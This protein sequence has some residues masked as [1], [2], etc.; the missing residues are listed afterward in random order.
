M[1]LGIPPC[2][3]CSSPSGGLYG[4]LVRWIPGGCLLGPAAA[5]FGFVAA[6]LWRVEGPQQGAAESMAQL[7][8][9]LMGRGRVG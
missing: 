7:V 8:A 9:A 4:V 1:G 2:S 5:G 6:L 3:T